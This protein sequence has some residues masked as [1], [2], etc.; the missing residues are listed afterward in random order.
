MKVILITLL[1][2]ISTGA[3]A[4]AFSLEHSTYTKH[5]DYEEWMDEDNQVILIEYSDQ[6]ADETWIVNVS[7]FNNTYSERSYTVG[8]GFRILDTT[9]VDVDLLGGVV[10]GYTEDQSYMPCS[11]D[12]CLY[13]APRITAE[14]RFESNF[15]VK[16]SL[17]FYGK[18]IINTIGGGYY[19]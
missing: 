9:Y 16:T 11:S 14:Y 17:Q 10:K 8:V 7:T 19:F 15:Y 5:L 6:Y 2:V 12:Y 1:L 18:A 13:I 3:Q 4:G